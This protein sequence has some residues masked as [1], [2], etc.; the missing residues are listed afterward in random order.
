M[1]ALLAVASAL[2]Y[3]LSDFVGGVVSRRAPFVRVAL[4]GQVGGLVSVSAVAPF[5]PGSVPPGGDLAW[6]AVS[7]VGT[8]VAMTFLFRGMSRGAMSVVVPVSSVGGAALPVLVGTALLGDRPGPRTWLG[9]AVALPALWAVSRGSTGPA[10]RADTAA[11]RD[12]LV[13]GVGIAAQYLALAQAGPASGL[14]PVASGRVTAILAVAVIAVAYHRPRSASGSTPG[15]LAGRV[16]GAV[17]GRVAGALVAGALAALALI[18]YLAATRAQMLTVAVVLSS[19]YPVIPVVLGLTVLRERL[20]RVQAL[21]L[22][23][24]LAGSV[25]IATS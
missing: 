8:G 22:V 2:S 15:A 20:S 6:G 10:A 7:G 24:A 16:A 3:G 13:A 1:G 9:V 14:W 25:L 11:V 5:V 12:G 18:C 21:G 23:A 17:A 19:L 4:L